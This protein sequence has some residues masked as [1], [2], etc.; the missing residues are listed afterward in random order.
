MWPNSESDGWIAVADVVGYVI[1]VHRNANPENAQLR[2]AMIA[3]KAQLPTAE[4]ALDVAEANWDAKV[5]EYCGTNTGCQVYYYDEGDEIYVVY[6]LYQQA[7]T[8]YKRAFSTYACWYRNAED[9]QYP[10]HIPNSCD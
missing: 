7:Y 6:N 5:N 10:G 9:S 1:E 4:Q 2:N 8:Q 3:A